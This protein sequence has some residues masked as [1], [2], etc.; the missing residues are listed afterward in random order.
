[1]EA[2]LTYTKTV[3]YAG[4]FTCL[5]TEANGTRS[6]IRFAVSIF[7]PSNCSLRFQNYPSPLRVNYWLYDATPTLRKTGYFNL[8]CMRDVHCPIDPE[9]ALQAFQTERSHFLNCQV[10]GISPNCSFYNSNRIACQWIDITGFSAATTYTMSLQLQ[11]SITGLGAGLLNESIFNF[12]FI[13]S[14]LPPGYV[15]TPGIITA[16]ILTFVVPISAIYI[17]SMV[18]ICR[19]RKDVQII[20]SHTMQ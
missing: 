16:S 5:P 7:N 20:Y 12:S 19:R 9:Q 8:T 1:M 11:P 10:S 6:L 17:A 3:I 14:Q 4:E 2:S 15:A 18:L 13:P